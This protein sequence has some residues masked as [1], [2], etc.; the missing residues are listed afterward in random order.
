M[1]LGGLD[2]SVLIKIFEQ[3]NIFIGSQWFIVSAQIPSHKTVLNTVQVS[4]VD[5]GDAC[6]IVSL[7]VSHGRVFHKGSRA[8]LTSTRVAD[9]ACLNTINQNYKLQL[10]K[11]PLPTGPSGVLPR[12]R[13][14][15]MKGNGC[16]DPPTTALPAF[17]VQNGMLI[18]RTL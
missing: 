3:A 12:Y 2:I 11:Q 17:A 13:Q 6:I 18:Y 7:I 9:R 8:E 1:N 14:V 10:A 16:G 5:D 4:Y 15:V